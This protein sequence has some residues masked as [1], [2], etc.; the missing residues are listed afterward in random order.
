MIRSVVCA[1]DC[2]RATI[3][4]GRGEPAFMSTIL[5]LKL[6]VVNCGC[7]C[8]GMVGVAPVA[9]VSGRRLGASVPFDDRVDDGERSPHTRC[10]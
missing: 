5:D 2:A 6:S 8:L 9:A 1:A 10:G 7:C 4:Y 3:R